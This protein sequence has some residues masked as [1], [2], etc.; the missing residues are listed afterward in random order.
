MNTE[1]KSQWTKEGLWFSQATSSMPLATAACGVWYG[2]LSVQP[3]LL[4]PVDHTILE[5]ST[6]LEP[7]RVYIVVS[8]WTALF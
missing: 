1:C 7:L 6:R 3:K 4:L 5:R 8:P 2:P